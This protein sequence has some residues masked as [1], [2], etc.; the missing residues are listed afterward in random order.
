M[1]PALS[2]RKGAYVPCVVL[3][4]ALGSA[5]MPVPAIA[6]GWVSYGPAAG[7]VGAIAISPDASSNLLA[8]AVV[9]GVFASAD[10]GAHWTVANS[11]LLDGFNAVSISALA[12]TPG[13]PQVAFAMG[14][15]GIY[16]SGD[17]GRTWAKV[18]AQCCAFG[19]FSSLA[20]SP[21][22]PLIAYAASDFGV[23]RSTDGGMTWS[24]PQSGVPSF[25]VAVVVHPTN[26]AIAYVGSTSVFMTSDGG[27]HWQPAGSGLSG[28]V[29][30][31]AID[32]TAPS[33]LFAGT[34]DGLFET[35]NGGGSWNQLLSTYVV[36]AIAIAPSNHSALLIGT[37]NG[38]ALSSTDGG[39][40]WTNLNLGRSSSPVPVQSVAID[41]GASGTLYVGSAA[42]LLKSTDGGQTWTLV[43][44]G[45]AALTF[46]AM[47]LDPTS[48]SHIYATASAAIGQYGGGVYVS[49]DAGKSWTD[50]AAGIGFVNAKALAVA[51]SAPNVL[52]VGTD[53]HLF[54]SADSGATWQE[55]DS[56]LPAGPN[57]WAVAV[58]PGS[59]QTAWAG[60]LGSG[61]FQTTNGG[62]SW[63]AVNTGLSDLFVHA[64]LVD[65]ANANVV[66][67]GTG[68]GIFK[69]VNGG[70][71]WNRSGSISGVGIFALALDPANESRIY[72]GGFAPSSDDAGY[73]VVYGSG[74]GGATWTTAQIGAASTNAP[75]IQAL[76][77]GSDGE[78]YAGLFNG[79]E[80]GGV[81]AS[82]DH[83][84][85]WTPYGTL[86]GTPAYSL[87]FAA[88]APTVLVAGSYTGVFRY[89]VTPLAFFTLTPCRIV[90]TR[91][92]PG[93]YGGPPLASGAPR[94]F[95]IQGQCGVPTSAQAVSANLTVVQGT[96]AG[97]LE[98]FN[99]ASRP[100]TSTINWSSQQTRA[101]NAIL[102]LDAS[103]NVTVVA[104][105]AGQ[106]SVNLLIDVN[107]YLQ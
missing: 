15:E 73:A 88:S 9:H 75:L 96:V 54:T 52:Y 2:S 104:G 16:R 37:L 64:L 61:I 65:P 77:V 41:P 102:A 47:A 98:V 14:D 107:G 93:T 99:G 66:Y 53:Q 7:N 51:P 58:S 105:M 101:N 32:P 74:D 55:A 85:G 3:W 18:L 60:T 103:G 25:P 80:S 95:T 39:A 76:A 31:L 100:S 63:S 21:S 45:L 83:G 12:F 87:V 28:Q 90:D 19:T 89:E 17:G 79:Y 20:V 86:P 33:T 82:A 8:A 50:S 56:G 13:N 44:P 23:F 106:G 57:I 30:A 48:S 70:S 68:D 92:A 59:A 81:Y 71:T 4:V 38:G 46:T 42:G 78:V 36:M 35:T 34:T 67:A 26:A 27:A 29:Q 97:F 1:K 11:G 91:Q 22:S 24:G 69:S 10:S 5:L 6:N 62:A 49:S 40:H 94:T 72:A 84:V 43:G